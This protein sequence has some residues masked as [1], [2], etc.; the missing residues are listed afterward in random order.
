MKVIG[1]LMIIML[2]PLPCY[3]QAKE[4]TNNNGIFI[5]HLNKSDYYYDRIC[6]INFKTNNSLLCA[7]NQFNKYLEIPNNNASSNSQKEAAGANKLKDTFLGMGISF[8]ILGL[9]GLFMPLPAEGERSDILSI[10]A[11]AL[12]VTGVTMTILGNLIK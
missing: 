4:V 1:L 6:D 5:E 8:S 9:Y 12:L 2:T 3:P 11:G 7:H 10:S